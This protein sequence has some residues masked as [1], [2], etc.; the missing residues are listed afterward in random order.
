MLL[1]RYQTASMFASFAG[2]RSVLPNLVLAGR[3]AFDHQWGDVP[4]THLDDIGGLY[5]GSGLGGSQTIR[6]LLQSQLIGKI[7]LL[8]NVETRMTLH[9]WTLFQRSLELVT[10][11]FCDTGRVWAADF[12]EG[13]FW[14]LHT[15]VGGGLRV[16]WDRVFVVRGDVGFGEGNVRYYVDIGHAF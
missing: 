14:R 3:L 10:A 6:G 2:Y 4:F 12:S 16:L 9:E 11:G 13:A 5:A 15:G 1:S 7:K 8:A